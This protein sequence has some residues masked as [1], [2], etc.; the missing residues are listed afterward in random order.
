[1]KPGMSREELPALPVTVDL[2][3]A[4]RALGIG[5]TKA[6]ELT[7]AGR[8]PCPVLRHGRTYVVP[9]AGLLHTL[10]ETANEQG[11]ATGVT[12]GRPRWL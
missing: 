7:R 12:L 5:R 2:V 10:G 8:F 1:M 3:T 4:A 6:Y 11:A 9:T